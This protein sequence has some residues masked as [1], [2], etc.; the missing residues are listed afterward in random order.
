MAATDK[1]TPLM[2]QYY[3]IKSQYPDCILFYRVGDFYETFADD[4]V[5]VSKVLGLV[6]TRKASGSGSYTNLAGV[7]HHAID[8]YLPKMVAA[9]YKVAIC[10]QLE[11]P[12]LTKKLV[13]RG[14]TELVTPGVNYNE[15]LLD[16]SK[17]NWLCA[18]YFEKDQAGAAFLDIST[19]SFRV[20]QGSL[21]F[22]DLLLADFAPKEILLQRGFEEGFR[23]RFK[24]KS[25][26]TAMESWAFVYHSA[27][28]KLLRQFETDSLKG[29]GVED[30]PLA[31]TAAG[32]VMAYLDLTEHKDISHIRSIGRIDR[33]EFMWIDRFTMRSL[34]ILQPMSAGGAALIDILDSCRSPMGSR[35]LR[36]WLAMPLKSP[37]AIKQRSDAVQA[38]YD[39]DALCGDIRDSIAQ[40]GDLE[41]IISRAAAGKILPREVLQLGR[42]LQNISSIIEKGRGVA[43]VEALV[44]RLNALETLSQRIF[45][46]IKGDTAQQI[47]KGEVICRGVDARLDDYRNILENSKQILLDIQQRERDATGISSLKISYNNVFGYYLEVRNT[48]K[49]M[50][51]AE[52]IRK[53]TLVGAERYITA[54]LK[55]YEEKIL[56]AQD[57]IVAIEA[58]IYADL[59]RELQ[60]NVGTIQAN[61]VAVSEL[62][63]LAAFA[64]N[65]HERGYHRP[66]VDDS[67]VIDIKQ[68]RHPVIE[69][70]MPEGEEYI[71]N[72]VM[73]DNCSQQIIILTGP[74]MAGKSALLR[75]TALIV[76]MA[77]IGSWVPAT[78]ARIGFVDKLFTRV[79]AS[80]NISRGESTFMVE[81]TESA[82][83][84]NN[85]SQRSLLLL[86]EI[87]RGTSTYDGM[88]I[89]WAIVEYLHA[90]P[91]APKTLFA[92]HYHEL[93]E[94]ETLLERVHNYHI[95][96]QEIDGHVIFLRK[97]CPGGVASSFGIHV[98][99]MAG[100][101]DA[102]LHAAQT[103]LSSLEKRDPS[104][105]L[106]MTKRVAPDGSVSRHLSPMQLSFF[107]LDDPLLLD[108]KHII[109]KIDINTISP[110][111]AFDTIRQIKN[112]LAG[113]EI[114]GDIV[115]NKK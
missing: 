19:G 81:M 5:V 107:Q 102:V 68:G 11:D 87:G 12:K 9:G 105:P 48:Y 55:E 27:Y 61:A 4:A 39:D 93:N 77:Q 8:I 79:G 15:T 33:G 2:Q 92:T 113:G 60:S 29:F 71:A 59:V 65:A 98:A 25:Y 97:L 1:N 20:A 44:S 95:S 56:V 47:G 7:P 115:S 83:I 72:D 50:V 17:N 37:A 40:I 49:D 112:K 75:Q 34:E 108:I 76:L 104:T 18:L 53:Q 6:L 64:F 38:L 43:A 23:Q 41:R 88:S 103:K 14:V 35:R 73:L 26:V 85:L 96:T 32:A 3:D 54:E 46:T 67:L 63:C 42:G 51:P 109:E 69:A 21:D 80:D 45:A 99:R 90:S 58:S 86:D 16:A 57:Q 106:G 10:D 78:A 100:M 114:D 24:D 28:K 94:M 30:M 82:T 84:L 62:D 101:P 66:D 110:L 31:I 13:K 36:E 111:N 91:L 74:N 89:A 22:V 70:F 52:W